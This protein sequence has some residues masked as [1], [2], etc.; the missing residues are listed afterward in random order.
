[1]KKK[2]S[3]MI[4]LSYFFSYN[5]RKFSRLKFSRKK[6]SA[7]RTRGRPTS[8]TRYKFFSANSTPIDLKFSVYVPLDIIYGLTWA[9]FLNAFF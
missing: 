1:M 7:A 3:I 2:S 6:I 5:V 9:F 4:I 8:K